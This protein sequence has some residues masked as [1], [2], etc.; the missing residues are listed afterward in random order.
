MVSSEELQNIDNC[1]RI[2]IILTR[3]SVVG[4]NTNNGAEK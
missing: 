2:G 1:P 4:E 3:A